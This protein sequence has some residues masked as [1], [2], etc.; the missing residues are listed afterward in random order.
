[1]AGRANR[2][3]V[4]SPKQTRWSSD[5]FQSEYDEASYGYSKSVGG[6]ILWMLL[7]GGFETKVRFYSDYAEGSDLVDRFRLEY[8]TLEQILREVLFSAEV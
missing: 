6:Y 4:M 5:R 2:F 1:M 8:K 7:G 3:V